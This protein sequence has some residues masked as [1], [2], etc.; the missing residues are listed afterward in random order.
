MILF[1]ASNEELNK[2]D[3]DFLDSSLLHSFNPAA[4]S[5]IPTNNIF[6]SFLFFN[7]FSN[8]IFKLLCGYRGFIYLFKKSVL[9]LLLILTKGFVASECKPVS[10]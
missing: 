9:R 8:S 7:A 5:H 3:K 4:S 2:G 1:A 6:F 10:K